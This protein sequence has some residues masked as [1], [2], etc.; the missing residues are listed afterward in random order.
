MAEYYLAPAA[1]DDLTQIYAYL[2]DRNGPVADRTLER[3]HAKFQH[4]AEAPYIG[5]ERSELRSRLRS[6]V[7]S[8]YVVFYRPIE[9]GIEIAR[10]LHGK[11]DLPRLIR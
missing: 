2:A 5:R 8:P 11:R 4:L 10:V 1:V 9:P 3:L 6:V 7:V